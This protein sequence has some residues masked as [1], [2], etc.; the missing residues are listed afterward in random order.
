VLL[1]EIGVHAEFRRRR[2]G[3]ALV[4]EVKRWAREV[5]AAQVWVLTGTANVAANA[6][7]TATGGQSDGSS[8]VMYSYS[9]E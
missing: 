3:S 7:Y 5:G 9:L 1:Y 2:I 6:L 8:T 4:G